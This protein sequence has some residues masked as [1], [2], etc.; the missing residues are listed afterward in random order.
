MFDLIRSKF[1]YYNIIHCHYQR[2][3]SRY[4]AKVV[5]KISCE[6]YHRFHVRLK[7]TWFTELLLQWKDI[8]WENRMSCRFCIPKS[9]GKSDVGPL[10]CSYFVL[11]IPT[12]HVTSDLHFKMYT[13]VKVLWFV[14]SRNTKGPKISKLGKITNIK[15]H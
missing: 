12:N 3:S 8:R 5:T 14:T 7:S 13:F 15:F 4:I 10:H 2:W 6:L 11:T 9:I 1:Q